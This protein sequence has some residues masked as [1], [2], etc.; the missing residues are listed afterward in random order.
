VKNPSHAENGAPRG[1]RGLRFPTPETRKTGTG[2]VRK[3]FS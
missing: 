2:I 3:M 1:G